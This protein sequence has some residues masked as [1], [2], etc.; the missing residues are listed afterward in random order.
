[1]RS[2]IIMVN[3]YEKNRERLRQKQAELV[4]V[5]QVEQAEPVQEE[6]E[7]D[8]I[9]KALEKKRN[10]N[11]RPLWQRFLIRSA[12]VVVK[13]IAVACFL[14]FADYVLTTYR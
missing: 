5:D 7:T 4:S 11:K 10:K 3:R 1:M 12:I 9:E 13:V 2:T 6:T 8:V 14:K